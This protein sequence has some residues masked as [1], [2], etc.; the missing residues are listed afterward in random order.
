MSSLIDR[1]IKDDGLTGAYIAEDDD[2]NGEFMNFK[3]HGEI[4][5]FDDS[6]KRMVIRS[7]LLLE[8]KVSLVKSTNCFILYSFSEIVQKR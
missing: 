8:K 6:K 7:V 2:I 4:E 3:R 1:K 5:G